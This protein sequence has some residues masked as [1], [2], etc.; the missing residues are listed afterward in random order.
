MVE[1]C[2]ELG[3][4]LETRRPF[5]IMPTS[6]TAPDRERNEERGTG[7]TPLMY[8]CQ[9]GYPQLVEFLIK[10]RA[11]VTACDEDG[12]RPLH[13]AC[14]AN[15][16]G[17]CALLLQS[18]ADP[19]QADDTGKFPIEFVPKEELRTKLERQKWEK[20]LRLN[21]AEALEKRP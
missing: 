18:G 3:A 21:G 7:L 12:T 11:N 14:S 1:Q 8:A 9:Q 5:V 2:V 15:E 4:F 19:R 13:F 17:I 16:P 10:A 6:R 20:V